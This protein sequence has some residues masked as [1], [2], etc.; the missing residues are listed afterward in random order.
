M[1]FGL[2]QLMSRFHVVALALMFAVTV[3]GCGGGSSTSTADMD[4]D[5]MTT[6]EPDP[7]PTPADQLVAANMALETAETAVAALTSSS[8]S[9][10]A[11]AAY[12]AMAEARTA[13]HAASNL[14]DNVIADLQSRLTTTGDNLDNANTLAMQFRA[15]VRRSAQRRAPSMP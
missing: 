8:T 3:A 5:G 9:E 6:T 1:L 2:K 15:V 11:A 7:E 12:G 10:E 13:V 14:P 4:G